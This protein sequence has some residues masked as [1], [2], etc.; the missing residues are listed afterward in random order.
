MSHSGGSYANVLALGPLPIAYEYKGYVINGWRFCM[1]DS[2]K[3]TQGSGVKIEAQAVHLEKDGSELKKYAYYGII[4][5]ILV[6]EYGNIKVPLF[7]CNWVGDSKN[8]IMHQ[9]GLTLVNFRK[10]NNKDPY[11]LAEQAIQV[12]YSKEKANEHWSV[13]MQAP[14]R[15]ALDD[16]EDVYNEEIDMSML[17]IDLEGKFMVSLL[18]SFTT[19]V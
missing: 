7:K 6:I 14:R 16:L 11:I 18:I 13:V 12:F 2:Q 3:S 1:K 17:N 5:K 19:Y 8:D 10:Q 9:D 15:S 4:E